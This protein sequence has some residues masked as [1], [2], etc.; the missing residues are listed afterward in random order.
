V[1]DGLAAL[2]GC[3]L[4]RSRFALLRQSH[5]SR[6]EKG[7]QWGVLCLNIDYDGNAWSLMASGSICRLNGVWESSESSVFA[8]G[9]GGIIL[10]YSHVPVGGTVCDVCGC[11]LADAD[12]ILL[13]DGQQVAQTVTDIDGVYGISVPNGVY[14]IL[15]AKEGYRERSQS[16]DITRQPYYSGLSW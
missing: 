8:V 1:S 6:S 11:P 9:A 3:P 14:S 16:V 15:A 2:L 12:V 4:S 13:S 7:R 10:H 5:L